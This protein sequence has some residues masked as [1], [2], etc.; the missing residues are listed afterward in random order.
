MILLNKPDPDFGFTMLQV[1]MAHTFRAHFAELFIKKIRRVILLTV[2]KF[3]NKG[4]T[5]IF[6]RFRGEWE[7]MEMRGNKCLSQL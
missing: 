6:S 3:R 7:I 4:A 1:R 5:F 2:A